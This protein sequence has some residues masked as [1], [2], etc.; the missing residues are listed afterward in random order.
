MDIGIRVIYGLSKVRAMF[1]IERSAN[2]LHIVLSVR[3]RFT[4]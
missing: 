4:F 2:D 1:E 3:L